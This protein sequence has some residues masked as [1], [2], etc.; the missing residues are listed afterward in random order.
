MNTFI[1]E[2]NGK[3]NWNITDGYGG[4][5]VEGTFQNW[6]FAMDAARPAAIATGGEII[7]KSAKDGRVVEHIKP[8][9]KHARK[10]LA[11]NNVT[12]VSGDI[13][14]HG[15][16]TYGDDNVTAEELATLP[17][18]TLVAFYNDAGG[19]ITGAYKGTRAKL[20]EKILVN[21]AA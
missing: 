4:V 14:T 16:D 17:T 18:K 9:V 13:G 11:V 10:S 1:V 20:I 15:D 19:K 6:V 7:R 5:A 8:R 12:D 3:G 21:I 2:R